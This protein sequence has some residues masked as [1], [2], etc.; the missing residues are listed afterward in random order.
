MY[1]EAGGEE[2]GGEVRPLTPRREER[3]VRVLVMPRKRGA[4]RTAAFTPVRR[5]GRER[6][7]GS[8]FDG[9]KN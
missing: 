7:Q 3:N 9:E 5:R 8:T 4:V 2:R 6:R 1:R